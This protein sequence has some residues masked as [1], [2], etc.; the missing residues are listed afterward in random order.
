MDELVPRLA[1]DYFRS[2][3]YPRWLD[4]TL[5]VHVI[6]PI[7]GQGFQTQK[8]FETNE[9]CHMRSDC[10]IRIIG[11]LQGKILRKP[12]SHYKSPN[13]TWA[14][15]D[16]FEDVLETFSVPVNSVTLSKESEFFH[17][18][19]GSGF[20]ETSA[21]VVDI[22]ITSKEKDVFKHLLQCMN[23]KDI[24]LTDTEELLTLWSLAD[25]FMYKRCC[26]RCARKLKNATLNME[27]CMRIIEVSSIFS[28]STASEM[29]EMIQVCSRTLVDHFRTLSFTNPL[30]EDD[31]TLLA[32]LKSL[33]P[34]SLEVLL[35][36]D[37]LAV[38]REEVAFYAMI[39]WV[40]DNA[41]NK[42]EEEQ[43]ITRMAAH[44]RYPFMKADVLSTLTELPE[45]KNPICQQLLVEG[46]KFRAASDEMKMRYR[47]GE[48]K[49]SRFTQRIGYN[50]PLQVIA[51]ELPRKQATA[52]FS[53]SLKELE[54]MKPGCFLEFEA[55][56]LGGSRFSFR[57]IQTSVGNN[58]SKKRIGLEMMLISSVSERV[59]GDLQV[60][61]WSQ[62]QMAF[63]CRFRSLH[64]FHANNP[65]LSCPD[66]LGR[67][68]KDFTHPI[69]GRIYI[70]TEF[71]INV[72]HHHNLNL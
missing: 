67:D 20:R 41:S 61:V 1:A 31:E 22:Y 68:L 36:S 27:Q 65:I 17:G 48:V 3:S 44:I 64:T 42:E 70:F 53:V 33:P 10:N 15:D 13:E 32:E 57:V 47:S 19:F 4:R 38:E 49:H 21:P 55:F 9:V 45:L 69:D 25:R 37:F 50:R 26:C 34:S 23:T 56:A 46:L 40:K 2:S 12:F 43:L 52:H 51:L 11:P 8:T 7:P 66:L 63:A 14:V 5:R 29:E 58:N 30:N 6:N 35:S 54:N 71:L 72:N 28:T 16:Q 39:L 59:L 24:S 18:L 60:F 62:T